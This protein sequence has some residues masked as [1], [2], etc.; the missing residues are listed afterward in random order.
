M[1]FP[2]HTSPVGLALELFVFFVVGSREMH[3]QMERHVV[4][5]QR[6]TPS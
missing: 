4:P 2:H 1:P 5:T 6:V 3:I